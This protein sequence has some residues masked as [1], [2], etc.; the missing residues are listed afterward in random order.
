MNHIGTQILETP[1][2]ILRP[3][4]MTDAPVMFKNWASDPEVAKYVTWPA[5]SSVEVTRMVLRDWT[6]GYERKNYYKWAI[7]LKEG[8]T[9]IGDISVG[10]MKEQICSAEIGYCMGR[11]WWGGGLMTEALEAVIRFMI[12]Q[13]GMNRLEAR[14]DTNNPASGRVMAK[15]GMTYEGTLRQCDRNNQGICDAAHYSIL[16]EEWE[17][18]AV[19]ADNAF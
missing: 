4:V 16:K 6:D 17:K 9:L 11:A 13:V 8:G 1:R 18:R 19:P 15:A 3:F 10:T 14:H 5:H 7:T 12:E 2:L